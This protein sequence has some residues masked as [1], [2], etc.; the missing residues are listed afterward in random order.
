VEQR[1][2]QQGRQDG[3]RRDTKGGDGRGSRCKEHIAEG[4]QD[5]NFRP[6][7][8]TCRGRH[9]M[10]VRRGTLLYSDPDRPVNNRRIVDTQW[11]GTG[12]TIQKRGLQG[13]GNDS[14]AGSTRSGRELYGCLQPT[15]NAGGGEHHPE[16]GNIV[17]QKVAEHGSGRSGGQGTERG[18]REERKKSNSEEKR[19]I[20]KAKRQCWARF[21]EENYEQVAN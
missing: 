5:R 1:K 17:L 8:R 20:R 13:A 4:G 15:E 16:D 14:G 9:Q 12:K 2:H 11:R 10:G 21:L 3:L 7:L 6:G 19:I 18:S